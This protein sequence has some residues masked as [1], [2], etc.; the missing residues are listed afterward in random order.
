MAA[1]SC[2]P[3]HEGMETRR[4]PGGRH[5]GARTAAVGA[6]VAGLGWLA[7]AGSLGF[8]AVATPVIDRLILGGR[9]GPSQVALGAVAWAVALTAP[10][11]F[12]ILGLSRLVA[13]IEAARGV[14]RRP[15]PV[16]SMAG[17]LDPA[18]FVAGPIVLPD[19]RRIPELV[20]G[21]HGVVVFEPLPPRG[22]TREH[23]GHWEVR[24]QDGRWIP[25]ENPLD[26]AE[27]DAER[28]RRWL[29]A[30]ERDFVVKV[31]AAL[32]APD[33]SLARTPGCAVITRDQVPAFLGSL[34]VQRSL[35][36]GRRA[37]LDQLI[38]SAG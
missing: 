9:V 5:P 19:G 18:S 7:L 31:Y 15:G 32:I 35:T 17:Q 13:A 27:R 28:V 1:R 22:A 20:V 12:A 2:R 4:I 6:A 37:R 29:V 30:D 23:G 11:A 16:A 8:L 33:A 21:P 34:P 26:R 3:H 36:A 25:L 14:R 38:R 10:A 24:L